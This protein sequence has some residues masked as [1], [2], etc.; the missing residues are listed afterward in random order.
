MAESRVQ[1]TLLNA[2]VNLI[3]YFLNLAVTFFSRK[4]FLD[5]LGADFF[6]LTSTIGGFI[7][8]LSLVELGIGNAICVTLY[9]PMFDK[10]YKKLNEIV[11][12]LGFLYYI[13]G[14]VILS[15]GLVLAMLFPFIFDSKGK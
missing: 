15:C 13:V 5:S 11:S 12:V 10:D 1:K 2:K 3:F 4:V 14:F 6:G 7:G 9:K 8:F